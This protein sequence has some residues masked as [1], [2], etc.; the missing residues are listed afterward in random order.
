M[1]A[2]NKRRV[3]VYILLDEKNLDSFTDMCTALDIQSSHMS[4]MRIRTTCGDTYCTKSGKKFSGQVLEKFLIID[5]EE[6]IAGS[7]R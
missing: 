3:P 5:C 1:E 4:N 7:Y 6:V 2:S